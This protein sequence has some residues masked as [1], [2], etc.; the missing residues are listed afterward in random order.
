M[1]TLKSP[2]KKII[3]GSLSFLLV[4]TP[5][6]TTLSQAASFAPLSNPGQDF[7]SK[8][9]QGFFNPHKLRERMQNQSAVVREMRQREERQERQKVRSLQSVLQ[10]IQDVIQT[11][12]SNQEEFQAE[13]ER[14]QRAAAAIFGEGGLFNFVKYADGKKVWSRVLGLAIP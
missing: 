1:N 14:R 13:V 2:F 3:A 9:E 6:A 4:Y 11:K 12:F 5:V 7:L 10:N 8:E